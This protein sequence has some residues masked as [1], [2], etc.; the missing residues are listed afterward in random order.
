MRSSPEV[1]M[2]LLTG[3][4]HLCRVRVGKRKVWLSKKRQAR[5][6]K[7]GCEEAVLK[8]TD[9]QDLGRR[10]PAAAVTAAIALTGVN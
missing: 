2:F 5:E 8:V 9:E 4:E 1:E 10:S 7:R 3:L 6:R